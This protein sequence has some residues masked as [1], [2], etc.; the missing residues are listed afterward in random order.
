MK[1]FAHLNEK[2]LEISYTG[3]PL[4]DENQEIIGALELIVDQTE[5]K[6]AARLAEKNVEIAKKQADF[7]DQEVDQLIVNLE[8]LAKGDLSIATSDRE[9]DEDTQRIGENFAKINT[10]LN[11]CV[12]AIQALIDDAAEMTTAAVEGRLDHR[13]DT[14]KHGGSFA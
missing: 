10:Y 7:Q 9:T 1:P 2:D 13:A 3:I 8:K 14:L 6:N 5:V 11:N 12:T 4:T